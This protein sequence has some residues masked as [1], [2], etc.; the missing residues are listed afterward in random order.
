MGDNKLAHA[1]TTLS[2]LKFLFENFYVMLLFKKSFF[3]KLFEL[4]NVRGY[5]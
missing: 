1:L 5:W 4:D 3:F 2:P